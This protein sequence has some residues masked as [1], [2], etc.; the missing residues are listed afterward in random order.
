MASQGI[1]IPWRA[2]NGF[3]WAGTGVVAPSPPRTAFC[4]QVH[5]L[6]LGPRTSRSH[7]VMP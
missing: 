2:D 1:A 4:L 7:T 3:G 5:R 6:Q